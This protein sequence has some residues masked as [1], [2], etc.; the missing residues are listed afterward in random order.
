MSPVEIML[1]LC[2]AEE[3]CTIAELSAMSGENFATV[4]DA[5]AIWKCFVIETGNKFSPTEDFSRIN[6]EV[7][8]LAIRGKIA[9]NLWANVFEV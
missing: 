9:N 4:E 1:V 3:P 6:I 8:L 2:E 5:L 7:D